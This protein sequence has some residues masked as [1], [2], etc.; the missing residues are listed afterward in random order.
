MLLEDGK[1][2]PSLF[3]GDGLHMNENGYRIW[4]GPVKT[5]FRQKPF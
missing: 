3:V 5:P 4:K 2:N 1:A